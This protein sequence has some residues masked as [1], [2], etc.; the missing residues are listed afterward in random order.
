MRVKFLPLSL[1]PPDPL[2]IGQQLPGLTLYQTS[3]FSVSPLVALKKTYRAEYSGRLA[4][5]RRG[6]ISGCVRNRKGLGV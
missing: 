5:G 6:R 3:S 4:A 1:G 2:F